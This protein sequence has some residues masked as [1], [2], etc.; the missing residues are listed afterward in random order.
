LK[1]ISTSVHLIS[2]E[3]RYQPYQSHWQARLTPGVTYVLTMKLSASL[4]QTSPILGGNH[5]S[6]HN[7][8][9][10][11]FL[12]KVKAQ[13]KVAIHYFTTTGCVYLKNAF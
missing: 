3:L 11:S 6:C 9:T 8:A 4:L 12:N 5:Q 13:F 7:D 1:S 10:K 2:L